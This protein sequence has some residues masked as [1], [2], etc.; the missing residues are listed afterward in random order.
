MRTFSSAVSRKF[1]CASPQQVTGLAVVCYLGIFLGKNMQKCQ[2]LGAED[3]RYQLFP[4]ANAEV[5]AGRVSRSGCLSPH[6]SPAWCPQLR[7]LPWP[8]AGPAAL[9]DSE[10]QVGGLFLCLSD[11]SHINKWSLL[12]L[13]LVLL[14]PGTAV[15]H[16]AGMASGDL[17]PPQ[18]GG[19]VPWAWPL[20]EAGG[21][22]GTRAGRRHLQ[23][24]WPAQGQLRGRE[25]VWAAVVASWGRSL[26][27]RM[28]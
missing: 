1:Y 20:Q 17:K 6:G 7:T 21:A 5:A 12:N 19:Q 9:G 14:Y 13:F 27:R 23:V 4:P 26:A 22:Q 3:T 2:L 10:P 28:L 18:V 8:R 11:K 16:L 24:R 25:R 15:R